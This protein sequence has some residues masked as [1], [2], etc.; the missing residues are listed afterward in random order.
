MS[1]SDYEFDVALSFAGENRKYVESVANELRSRRVKVFYDKY[2]R[3]GMWGKDLYLH[4]DDVYRNKARYCVI[5]I[6][7]YYAKKL[8]TNHE[9][10]S[11][12]A[13]ALSESQEYILPARFDDTEI[14]GLLPTID[15]VDLNITTP[16]ELAKML[17]QKIGHTSLTEY[18]PREPKTFYKF[19]HIVRESKAIVYDILMLLM[20]ELK[21]TRTDE[22]LILYFLFT[23]GCPADLPDNIHINIDVL[24]RISG[25]NSKKIASI[26][27]GMS[28]L[29]IEGQIVERE[30]SGWS[31]HIKKHTSKIVVVRIYSRESAENITAF[32][33]MVLDSFSYRLCPQCA[34]EAFNRL[35][36]SCLE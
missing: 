14:P 2:E 6:S 30:Q 19:Y 20:D 22:R 23:D 26:V 24:K 32:L 12:Q 36:F 28:S 9:R 21:K 3:V 8:L 5:F 29:G 25:F 10:R 7:K 35:D 34:E 15:Y 16:H 27:Q 11:A 1:Q 13:R 4:L 18:M 33:S 31:E 17:V